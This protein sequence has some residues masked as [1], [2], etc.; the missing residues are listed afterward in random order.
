M[1]WVLRQ[2]SSFLLR[3]KT[4]DLGGDSHASI[5]Q[6][7]ENRCQGKNPHR[8]RQRCRSAGTVNRATGV[9]CRNRAGTPWQRGG[10]T[11]RGATRNC[12]C[13]AAGDHSA[14]ITERDIASWR[15]G[16]PGDRRRERYRLPET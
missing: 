8:L 12:Y 7:I 15:R 3:R 6:E 13:G 1:T 14:A 11:L 16:T 4:S 2:K 10:G 5:K 9:L